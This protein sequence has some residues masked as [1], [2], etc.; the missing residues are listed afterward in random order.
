MDLLHETYLLDDY[1]LDINEDDQELTLDYLK[2]GLVSACLSTS[3]KA[4]IGGMVSFVGN[5]EYMLVASPEFKKEYFAGGNLK[6]C[7]LRAPGIKFDQNDQLHERYLEKIFGINGRDLDYQIIPSVKGFKM[8]ALLGMG[9]AFIPKIDIIKELKKKEL[10]P[11]HH[12]WKIPIYWHYW[13]I[14]SEPY[15]KFNRNIIHH[16][17]KKLKG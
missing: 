1:L 2:K 13:A 14:E 10:V 3:Q 16:A 15:K 9:Y 7:L 6:K 17:M 11:I 5:M 8:S 4:I 12:S